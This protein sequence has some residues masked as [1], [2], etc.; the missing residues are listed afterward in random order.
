MDYIPVKETPFL[1]GKLSLFQPEKG[2]RFAIDS[3]LLANFVKLKPSEIAV[4]FG[5]GCGVISSILLFK[6][7]SAKVFAVEKEEV[8]LKCLKLSLQKNGF[9][10]R[11]LIIKADFMAPPFKDNSVD[12]VFLNP[13]YFKTGAG[14][15]SQNKIEEVARRGKKSDLVSWIKACSRVLK[16]GGKLFL[17]FTALRLAELFFYL[18]SH[19]LEPKELRLVYSYPGSEAKL[20]LIKCVKGAGEELR[21]LPPLFIYEYKKGPYTLEVEK[22]LN[23]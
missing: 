16:T 23:G 15:K 22:M 19:K 11:L 8:F 7:K 13:P 6:N 5:A 3:V 17:I 18:K 9:E 2:Y 14:R 4:E 21:I 10:N 1:K 12:V 20:A